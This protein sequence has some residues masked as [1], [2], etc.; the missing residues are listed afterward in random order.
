MQVNVELLLHWVLGDYIII[1]DWF[2]LIYLF[3]LHHKLHKNKDMVSLFITV[4]T[5][6]GIAPSIEMVLT[7]F[8]E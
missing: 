8:V 1:I 4:S 3:S 7:T 5:V 2:A 6:W